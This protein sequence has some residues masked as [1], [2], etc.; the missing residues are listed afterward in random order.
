MGVEPIVT[1]RQ[2]DRRVL[3]KALSFLDLSGACCS[4]EGPLQGEWHTS[5][6]NP[7]CGVLMPAIPGQPNAILEAPQRGRLSNGF[8]GCEELSAHLSRVVPLA[9]SS[10]A[11][12]QLLPD[13]FAELVT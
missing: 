8:N 10:K 3:A 2:W 11:P 12:S 4:I 9:L 5:R 13:A 1:I 6:C 7:I